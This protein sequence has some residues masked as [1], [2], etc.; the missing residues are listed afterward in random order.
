MNFC[1]QKQARYAV[2]YFFDKLFIIVKKV[3]KVTDKP[4][5][6]ELFFIGQVCLVATST[7]VALYL[8]REALVAVLCIQSILSNLFVTKQIMLF[9]FDVTASDAYAVGSIFG[10]NLLQ[11]FFGI[12][13]VKKTI[14]INFFVMI[15]YLL[16]SQ[17]HLAYTANMFDVTQIHF[18][19][20]MTIMPRLIASSLFSY[21]VVQYSDTLVY[22]WLK[23]IFNSKH[24]T[25]RTTIS[26]TL[27]QFLDTVIFSLAAL[28]G[29]VGSLWQVILF[30][31]GIKICVIVLN[32]PFVAL[33]KKIVKVEHKNEQI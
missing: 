22:A 25:L 15:F 10:L 9:G 12:S 18:A 13:L 5:I 17:I 26:L 28:H 16:A 20:I 24:L 19:A 4:M 32:S 21:L 1:P 27:S 33:S 23:K 2:I 11:E 31:F 3:F 7:L 29:V 6:N 30:S 8:G 14:F